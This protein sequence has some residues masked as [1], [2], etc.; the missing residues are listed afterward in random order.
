MNCTVSFEKFILPFGT[1]NPELSGDVLDDFDY[2]L[3][4]E[5]SKYRME[6]AIPK[7]AIHLGTIETEVEGGMAFDIYDEYYLLSISE[8]N[9]N[10]ALFRLSWDDNWEKW[11]WCFDAR[12]E[13]DIEDYQTLSKLVLTKLWDHWEVDWESDV[14]YSDLLQA[15]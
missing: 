7:E 8:G 12:I 5:E 13:S 3:D 2:D 15:I 9:F 11:Q 10:W 6:N 1:V 14:L 4:I